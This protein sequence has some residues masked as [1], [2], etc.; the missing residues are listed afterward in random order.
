MWSRERS[1]ESY[2][3]GAEF[4]RWGVCQEPPH[5][6]FEKGERIDVCVEEWRTMGCP[7]CESTDTTERRERTAIG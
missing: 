2:L 6:V 1:Q 5:L 4:G 3:S 7:H